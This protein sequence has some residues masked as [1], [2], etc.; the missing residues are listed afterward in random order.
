VDVLRRQ[1]RSMCAWVDGLG[2]TLGAGTLFGK[3]P[4]QPGEWLD[5]AAPPENPAAAA[6][7]P[8]LLAT[9][10][11]VRAAQV[12]SDI[13]GVLGKERRALMLICL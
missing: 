12:L 11:R 1:Y 9:A 8:I 5:P 7:D 13:A 4:F 2:A 3:P 10:Y 6:T